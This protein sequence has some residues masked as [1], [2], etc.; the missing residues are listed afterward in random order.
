[1]PQIG[2]S[3]KNQHKMSRKEVTL[4]RQR[5]GHSYITHSYLLK[6]GEGPI[7]HTMLETLYN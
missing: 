2:K 1:M 3:Q 6:K 4:S 5:I 7:L